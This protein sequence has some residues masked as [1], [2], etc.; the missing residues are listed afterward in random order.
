MRTGAM[1]SR[2]PLALGLATSVTQPSTL[3]TPKPCAMTGAATWSVRIL[4]PSA[5]H[6]AT[7]TK[8]ATAEAGRLRASRR[9]ATA[10]VTATAAMASRGQSGGSTF[11]PR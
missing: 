2:S 1:T 6:A 7:A 3:A 9:T 11:R 4:P 10:A 8:A 5:P